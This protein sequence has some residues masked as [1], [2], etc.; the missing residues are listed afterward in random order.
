MGEVIKAEEGSSEVGIK[1]EGVGP[2]AGEV[3]MVAGDMVNF[4]LK[5]CFKF[6]LIFS[7]FH[8]QAGEGEVEEEADPMENKS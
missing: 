7:Y 8:K 4:L 5:E 6:L 1:A 3:T 2:M